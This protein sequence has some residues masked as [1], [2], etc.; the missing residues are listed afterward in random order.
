MSVLNRLKGSISSYYDKKKTEREHQDALRKEARETQQL[1]YEQE[2]RKA[3]LKAGMIKARRDAEKK[4]G[5]AKLRA[6]NK[7]HA[8]GR[9]RSGFF[10]RLHEYTQ[11]NMA[12]REA[13]LKK[14]QAIK[15]AVQE[16]KE[17]RLKYRPTRQPRVI[18]PRPRY[19]PFS[20]FRRREL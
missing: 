13:N 7:L 18:T 20:E 5:L 16:D 10:A 12:A 6:I 1:I 11:A 15:K 3:S 9:P 2:F 8:S 19:V 4:T 17:I 14:T